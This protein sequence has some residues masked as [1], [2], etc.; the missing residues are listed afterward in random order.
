MAYKFSMRDDGI[1]QITHI[2]DMKDENIEPYFEDLMPFI[3]ATTEAE[4]LR[5]LI[6]SSR[7]GKYSAAFRKKLVGLLGAPR[8]GKM[9]SV[10]AKRYSRVLGSFFLKATGRDNLRFFESEEE[11]LVWLKAES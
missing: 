9:A 11:A 6:D 10:G 3:E 1:L 4:P 7:T 2:G 5:V 8:L